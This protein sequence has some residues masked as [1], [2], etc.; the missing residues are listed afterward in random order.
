LNL[1]A[2]RA[3]KKRDEEVSVWIDRVCI[4]SIGL[5][6]CVAV[7]CSGGSAGASNGADSGA[8]DAPI[9]PERDAAPPSSD[10]AT[11]DAAAPAD[12]NA[13]CAAVM[14]NCNGIGLGYPNYDN[15]MKNCS[16][17]PL[18]TV[19][20]SL[21][22]VGCRE[23][24]AI[25]AKGAPFTECPLAEPFPATGC[26]DRCDAFCK[27]A[28]AACGDSWQGHCVEEC[29]HWPYDGDAGNASGN[30]LLCREDNVERALENGDAGVDDAGGGCGSV[31]TN[32][33]ECK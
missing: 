5:I 19:G 1:A 4:A 24:H 22:T 28:I 7:G 31:A 3:R 30:S 20:D 2:K 6:T 17:L 12:C 14:G 9:S 33:A 11:N 16:A 13:Y 26:G 15:C 10:A 23:A 32:S 27:I 25:A 29:S 18:G 21:D 8:T